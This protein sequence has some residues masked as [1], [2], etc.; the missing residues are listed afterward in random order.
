MIG[1]ILQVKVVL[2]VSCTVTALGVRKA[3]I[4]S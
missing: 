4:C 3:V 2:A 1:W